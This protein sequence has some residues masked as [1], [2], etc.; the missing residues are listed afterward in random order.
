MKAALIVLPSTTAIGAQ[1]A[2]VADAPSRQPERTIATMPPQRRPASALV[3]YE[4]SD[5]ASEPTSNED[6][7]P[8]PNDDACPVARQW[9]PYAWRSVIICD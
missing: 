8:S 6:F 9:T 1:L 5:G 4:L 3:A 7:G 2:I